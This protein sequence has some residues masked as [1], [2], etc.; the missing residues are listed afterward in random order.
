MEED[1]AA[2]EKV[3]EIV[4]TMCRLRPAIATWV[5]RDELG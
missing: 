2:D 5:A 4:V 3:L 1:G